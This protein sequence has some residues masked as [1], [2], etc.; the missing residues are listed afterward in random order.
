MFP[1]HPVIP[2][3]AAFFCGGVEVTCIS[4]CIYD[5]PLSDPKSHFG[6]TARFPFTFPCPT[7]SPHL[8]SNQQ[9]SGRTVN[10]ALQI[11]GAVILSLASAFADPGTSTAMATAIGE[12]FLN[13]NVVTRSS[14]VLSGDR[15]ATG[16]SAALVLHLSGSSIHIGPGSEALYRATSLELI[17]GSAEVHGRESILAG[18]HTLTPT[19]E[20]RFTVQ[21]ARTQTALHLLSG[22]LQLR[23][24]NDTSTITTPGDYTL[25]DDAPAPPVKRRAI[26]KALPIAAGTAAGASIVIAHWLT[27]KAASTSTTCIS[28]KSPTSCK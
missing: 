8:D 7:S 6:K 22:R 1:T 20:S 15:L 25:Q 12:A 28:G 19:T 26:T 13:G 2:S 18:R 16:P 17:S 27:G 11:I 3:G 9:A 10:R 21:R 5:Y 24:G 23:H 4:L 14:A